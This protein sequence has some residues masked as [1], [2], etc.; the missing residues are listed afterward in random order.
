MEIH[1]RRPEP[2]K[3]RE[4]PR[5]LGE[6]DSTR[7][8]DHLT[9]GRHKLSRRTVSTPR[10]IP[11]FPPHHA[12]RRDD[13]KDREGARDTKGKVMRSKTDK[14]DV[15]AGGTSGIGEATEQAPTILSILA[16]NPDTN[17]TTRAQFH[18]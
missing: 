11:Q 7:T 10:K 2:V 4:L 1:D 17:S 3:G 18:E 9:N 6:I 14:V 5:L 13:P 12:R 8:Q 16:A 15:L